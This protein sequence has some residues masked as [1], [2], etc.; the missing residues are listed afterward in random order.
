MIKKFTNLLEC[1]RALG[2][3]IR[4]VSLDSDSFRSLIEA[5]VDHIKYDEDTGTLTF[6]G[7]IID[8]YDDK[9]V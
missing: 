7:V 8:I 4:R 3:K 6:N 9:K 5:N 1:S 2:M